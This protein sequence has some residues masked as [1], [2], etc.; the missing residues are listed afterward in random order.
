MSDEIP[1]DVREAADKALNAAWDEHAELFGPHSNTISDGLWKRFVEHSARAIL[2]ERE[3]MRERC[4][5][6]ADRAADASSRKSAEETV[7][8]HNVRGVYVGAF[9]SWTHDAAADVAQSIAQA[10]RSSHE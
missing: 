1:E 9:L 6:I 7:R 8:G 3:A 4:A 10:I 2:A 5:K